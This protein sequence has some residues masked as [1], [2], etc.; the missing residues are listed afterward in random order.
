MKDTVAWWKLIRDVEYSALPS[1]HTGPV[2]AIHVAEGRA[3]EEDGYVFSCSLDNTV[4]V[5]D[6]Y[7]MMCLRVLHE[8]R[9]ELSA[10][11]GPAAPR[12]PVRWVTLRARW[13]TLRARWVTL[14]ARWVTLRARWVTLRARW[15]TLRARWVTL[16]ARV[17]NCHASR[18][19]SVQSCAWRTTEGETCEFV[20]IDQ[21]YCES[22]KILVTGHDNGC[23][24]LW[25]LDTGS[26][27]NMTHHSNTVSCI[28]SATL[29]RGEEFMLTGSFDGKVGIWDVRK[30]SSVRPHLVSM[31]EAH[32]HSEVLC[33]L[34]DQ[35]KRTIITAGNDAVR[36][37]RCKS[38][39]S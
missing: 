14:R 7:D 9:S 33:L 19:A 15:V 6:P 35:Y 31:F 23:V 21:G 10:L 32:P 13:V 25:N 34:F 27:I 16:R 36:L 22:K 17:K 3:N 20:R 29:K 2:F 28:I 8:D 18:L 4:R 12:S 1:G 37:Q 26:T 30:K 39:E 24:R 5:W 11:V 38:C